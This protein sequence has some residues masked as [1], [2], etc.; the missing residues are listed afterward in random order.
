M[1]ISPLAR[2]LLTPAAV[3]RQLDRIQT[4]KLLATM[5]ALQL[6]ISLVNIPM[7]TSG[8][9]QA[10]SQLPAGMAPNKWFVVGAALAVSALMPTLLI[11]FMSAIFFLAAAL[12]GNIKYRPL[13]SMTALASA[14][15]LLAS[16]LRAILG[17]TLGGDGKSNPLS[18]AAL[19]HL[20]TAPGWLQIW[21]YID[22]FDLW[23]Y[24]LVV[25]G[26]AWTIK[27]RR[28]GAYAAAA[29]LWGLFQLVLL[30]VQMMGAHA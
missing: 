8:T 15:V 5:L 18:F 24:A 23:T 27:S 4:G 30:K 29:L 19:L 13:L 22:L 6:L 26:F 11:L 17:I 1:H 14:P 25:A 20:D 12:A 10:L 3:F 28:V 16:A 9:E 2:V 21:S 7:F